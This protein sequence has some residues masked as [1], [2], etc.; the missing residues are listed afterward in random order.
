MTNKNE[1]NQTPAVEWREMPER[2]VDRKKSR[3]LLVVEE[4]K[5]Q[6]GRSAR[7]ARNVRSSSATATWRAHQCVAQVR[8]A[9]DNPELFDVYAW[10]PKPE[11][12]SGTAGNANG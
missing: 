2:K 11:E 12:S 7:V 8:Q 9:E 5:K 10:W 4:L 3:V 1:A 6:P